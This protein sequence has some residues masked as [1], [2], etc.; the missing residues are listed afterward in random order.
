MARKPSGVKELDFSFLKI[1]LFGCADVHKFLGIQVNQ[2][3]PAALYLHH[4]SMVF[5]ESM[6]DVVQVEFYFVNVIHNQWLRF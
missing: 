2:R 4:Y 6:V 1:F 3:K 5:P